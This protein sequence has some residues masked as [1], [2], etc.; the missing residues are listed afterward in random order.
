MKIDGEPTIANGLGGEVK[1][2]NSR[3]N[4]K[5]KGDH[6]TY[7]FDIPVQVILDESKIPVLLGRDGF[8]SYFRIEFDHDNERIR[9]I[10]NNVVDFNLKNK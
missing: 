9:L 7:Q 2:V 4:L 5:I 6:T 8:F 10:R 3:M 1:V